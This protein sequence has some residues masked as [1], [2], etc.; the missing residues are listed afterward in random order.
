LVK[1]TQLGASMLKMHGIFLSIV[2]G[3][4]APAKFDKLLGLCETLLP[5]K[6]GCG[7]SHLNFSI[8]MGFIGPLFFTA[9]RAPQRPI[10]RRAYD[11]LLQA[12]GREGMWDTEDALRIA[13]EAVGFTGYQEPSAALN[14]P[15]LCSQHEPRTE[16]GSTEKLQTRL[17]WLEAQKEEPVIAP[18]FRHG[19]PFTRPI[20]SGSG[21]SFTKEEYLA[22]DQSGN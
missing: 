6:T 20:P 7:P 18:A 14:L 11:M 21:L 2:I 16:N 10:Q 15:R 4:H 8:G 9:L 17:S 13:G 22:A 3:N 12:P 19:V 5:A 1:K